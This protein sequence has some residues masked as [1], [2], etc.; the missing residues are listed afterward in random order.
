MTNTLLL[1]RTLT[2]IASNSLTYGK[3]MTI[4]FNNLWLLV[5]AMLA[6]STVLFCFKLGKTWLMSY[7]AIAIILMNIFVVKQATIFGLDATL[8][9]VMYASI[10]LATDL[11]SEHYGKKDAFKAVRIGFFAAVLGAIMTQFALYYDPNGFDFAQ[12]S[13]ETLFTL[14]P[15]IVLAS[16]FSYVIVQH[17]DI[18][19]FHKL[20]KKTKNKHLWLRNNLSTLAAQFVDSF[21]FTYMA[22][23]GVFEGL[24]E[25]AIFTFI[26]KGS[27]A[28][29]DTPILYLSK[30]DFF[31]QKLDSEA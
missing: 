10:F 13:F 19:I 22:F 12:G 20:K 31:K 3:K 4:D 15:R 11:L 25:I 24:F 30:L 29:F 26:I 9:N 5:H 7:V 27:I 18:A 23:Y 6:L 2:R 17:L 28:L 8:G 14:T 1:T 16:L 21:L